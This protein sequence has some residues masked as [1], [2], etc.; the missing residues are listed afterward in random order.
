MKKII[1]KPVQKRQIKNIL[2]TE[3]SV[4]K[5]FEVLK[6]QVWSQEKVMVAVSGGS[7]SILTACLLYNFFIKNKYSL[8]NL[9][10]IHCNHWTRTGNIQDE[11]F[12]RNFCTWTQ[13]I[14]ITRK[15][16]KKN[17]ENEM[18]K[19]RYEVFKKQAKKYGIQKIIF[20][21]NLTDRIESTFLNLL[22]G[23]NI[24]GLLAMKECESHHLLSGIQV[25]RPILGLTKQEVFELCKKYTIPFI[26][27]P[28]NKD[29]TTSLRNR[30]RNKV[31][32][33]LYTL[34][35][36]QD[37]TTN[38]F[39]ESMKNIYTQLE[40][41]EEK[42]VRLK[43]IKKSAH[44]KADFA[45]QRDIEPSQVTNE[46]M[47]AMMKKLHISNNITAPLLHEL[48]RF[49]TKSESGYKYVNKTY[50]FKSHSNIYIISAPKAFWEK[51][52]DSEKKIDKVTVKRF[53][54]KGDIHKGKTRNQRCINQK[55]P[56]F[57]RNF[58]PILAQKNKVI[59]AFIPYQS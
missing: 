19:W 57:R 49:L 47:M 45:Y 41:K 42:E 52:I 53:P 24:N 27:D 16:S 46:N 43:T 20:W 7:D 30:L 9:F 15:A 59:N 56:V 2:L 23:A 6:E 4:Q 35:N 31:L 29:N 1:K 55:I 25:I 10:F 40:K 13:L 36:K 37:T 26:T 17:T 58:I 38:S 50:V 32:P 48:T 22:R 34:A 51:T 54:R 5:Y 44:R 12:V 33:Q 8:Q 39:I 14:I 21:H 11:E 3:T 28:T 18:R